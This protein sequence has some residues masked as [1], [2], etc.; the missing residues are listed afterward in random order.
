MHPGLKVR[1]LGETIKL[2]ATDRLSGEEVTS[3]PAATFSETD[4]SAK[5]AAVGSRARPSAGNNALPNSS[6]NIL[7][8]NHIKRVASAS[9]KRLVLRNNTQISSETQEPRVILGESNKRTSFFTMMDSE[10][11]ISEREDSASAERQPNLGQN[12]LVLTD[13][14]DYRR[15]SDATNADSTLSNT[16]SAGAVADQDLT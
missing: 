14:N 12:C 15:I 4:S 3:P 8:E 11:A 16:R 9:K 10:D 13:S 6:T 2:P 5:I 1:L 7:I